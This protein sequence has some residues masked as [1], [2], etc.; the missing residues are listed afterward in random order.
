[1]TDGSWVAFRRHCSSRLGGRFIVGNLTGRNIGFGW[2]MSRFL[3]VH[4]AV[5][6]VIILECKVLRI[7]FVCPALVIGVYKFDNKVHNPGEETVYCVVELPNILYS[8]KAQ[9]WV[10]P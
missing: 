8:Y 4:S 7:R 5:W 9:H 2:A 10:H 6:Q 3:A 1:V